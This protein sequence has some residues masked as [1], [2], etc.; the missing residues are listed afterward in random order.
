MFHQV[1]GQIGGQR[2]D[3]PVIYLDV[4]VPLSIVHSPQPWLALPMLG[5]GREDRP[6]AL[7]L[8]SDNTTHL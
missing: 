5:V 8:G 4:A 3:L 6:R 1:G 2:G 7:S